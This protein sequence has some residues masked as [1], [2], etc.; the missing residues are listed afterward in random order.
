[1]TSFL[2]VVTCVPGDSTGAMRDTAPSLA[3]DG[4]TMKALPPFERLA[5][6]TKSAWPPV[7][8]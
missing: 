3:V 8:E 4:S 1:L 6:R 7:P 5:A 2:L